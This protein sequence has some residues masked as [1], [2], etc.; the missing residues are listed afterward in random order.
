MLGFRPG[1]PVWPCAGKSSMWLHA[2]RWNVFTWAFGRTRK[3]RLCWRKHV[4]NT[5]FFA[6][7]ESQKCSYW[8]RLLRTCHKEH[9]RARLNGA[10]QLFLL[11]TFSGSLG[12]LNLIRITQIN[13]GSFANPEKISLPR[14]HKRKLMLKEDKKILFPQTQWIFR[15]IS[16]LSALHKSQ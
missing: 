2:S 9:T 13:G 3:S 15:S 8:S 12:R 5:S 1:S 7:G 10:K 11:L 6:I 4:L 14:W 16:D